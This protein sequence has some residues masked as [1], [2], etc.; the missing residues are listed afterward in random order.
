MKLVERHIITKQNKLFKE[1]DT[2]AF[3][4]KNLYN[5]ANYL[6][7]QEFIN[8]NKYLSNS[9]VYHLIK[10]SV[11]YKALPAKVSNQVLRVLE[12]NWKSFLAASREFKIN[13]KKFLGKPKLP[14][15]KD[16]IKGRN[17]VIYE[18]GALSKPG[19]RNG[20]VKLSKT[21]IS[22][23]TKQKEIKEV[24]LVPRCSVYVIEI[25]YEVVI[26]N[27]HSAVNSKIAAIDLGVD[28]LAT[29]SSNAIGFKP[30]IINGKP[31]KSVNQFYNKKKAKLQQDLQKQEPKRHVSNQ[32]NTLT[33]KRNHKIETYLHQ[34]SR[35]IINYLLQNQ[36][37]TLVIGNNKEWKQNI[38]I[39]KTNNQNFVQLP[40]YKFIQQLAYKAELA[41]IKVIV[42]EESYTS[43]ASFLDLDDIPTYKAG[44]KHNFS[45][46]RIK[47]GMYKSAKGLLINAD[48]NGSYNILRKVVPNA[49]T[50]GIEGLAVVPFR[51]T[52]G[53]VKL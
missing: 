4:S 29:V 20:L 36:I 5:A 35:T 14:K 26:T 42:N 27:T 2:L 32:I 28:N 52:P 12:R 10:A 17:I 31:I 11:D 46:K 45:G 15:Y 6:I 1:I 43:R 24:R 7:R 40:H 13:P 38:N 44:E 25:V 34:A 37:G 39:G 8:N 33:A 41:R 53:K 47:R 51:F 19:L 3:L 23:T 30:L 22:I 48:L 21:N 49:F 16:K 9:E 50:E 18:L